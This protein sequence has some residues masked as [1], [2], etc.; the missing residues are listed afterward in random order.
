MKV[1]LSEYIH[2]KALEKL[3]ERAEITD[4][5]NNPEEIDAI[6]TRVV[7]VNRKIMESC[8]NLKV[9]G[10]HGI[11]YNNIDVNSAK[12][13]GIKV[14]YTPLANVN[15]VAELIVTLILNVSRNI[16]MVNT[17]VRNSE[18]KT[19]APKE[20]IGIEIAGKTLG[21]VGMGNIARTAASI[22][23]NGFGV[24][25]IGYDPFLTKE[26]AEEFGITK[27]ETIEELIADSDIVNISVPL[28]EGTR[29]LINEKSFDH[30]KPD[31]ILINTARGGI[32]NEEALYGALKNG[33][34]RGA[35]C[36]V[37]VNEPPT[38]DNP[39][40]S[41]ANFIATP[42]VGANT[43]EALF[44]MGMTVVDEIFK[45]LDGKEPNY[46]VK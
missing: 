13:L 27:Y 41:L 22:L 12:D 26:R 23:K 6:L 45:V 2:P 7:D 39:L 9:I 24:K 40:V 25:V 14:V 29:N 16:T 43:E 34:L 28:T 8:K 46:P 37:F 32:V 21:L 44:R 31:A 1:Y 17:K 10:K 11:G 15:S 5:F 42:H 20:S 33:K 38:G 30:F 35:A 36:D 4:N 19:I 3:R 18:Y